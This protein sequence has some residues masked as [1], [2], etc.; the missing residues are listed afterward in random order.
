[1]VNVYVGITIMMINLIVYVNNV[2][3]F[4]KFSIFKLGLFI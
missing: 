2:K 3:H 1:M 4:G